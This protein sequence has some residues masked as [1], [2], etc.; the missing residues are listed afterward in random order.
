MAHVIDVSPAAIARI[1]VR[2]RS[3]AADDVRR[4]HTYVDANGD[5]G[6]V[7]RRSTWRFVHLTRDDLV[8]PSVRAGVL[9]LLEQVRGTA[10]I[11]EQVDEFLASVAA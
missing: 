6:L 9:T 11:D 10:R 4:V 7:V 2:R 8:D 5:Q 3:I 1:G